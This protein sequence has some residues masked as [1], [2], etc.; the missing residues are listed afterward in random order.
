VSLGDQALETASLQGEL[1]IASL[2]QIGIETTAMLNRAERVSGDCEP[3]AHF[4][5]IALQRHIAQ[6]RQ[7]TTPRPTLGMAHI[8]AGEHGFAG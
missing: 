1:L 4:E 8:V 7:E 3:D 2:Q 6:I 5:R